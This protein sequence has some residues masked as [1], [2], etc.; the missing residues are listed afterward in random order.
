MTN[1]D[2][3]DI[4]TELRGL[5]PARPPQ[6]LM[7]RLN[8][9]REGTA[10]EAST[11]RASH[12]AV[13]VS[14]LVRWWPAPAAAALVLGAVLWSKMPASDP[15]GPSAGD[16]Q[17]VLMADE[18]LIERHLVAAYDSFARLPDGEPIRYRCWEWID[19]VMVR[20]TAQGIVIHQRIPRF[21]AFP[22]R[23]ETY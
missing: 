6:D 8:Q 13:L 18:V 22:V 2:H 11:Q 5:R 9:T 16:D 7:A 20:D 3:N 10:P 14:W 12:R 23:F 17:P 4:E 15:E 21:E 1:P 19:E